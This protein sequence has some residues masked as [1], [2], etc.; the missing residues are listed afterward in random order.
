MITDTFDNLSPVIINPVIKDDAIEVDA[1]IL[2]L[3]WQTMYR[4]EHKI[5]EIVGY[6]IRKRTC[7]SAR[8]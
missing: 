3:L 4:I 2:H 6:R 1:C 8:L 5:S 7:S